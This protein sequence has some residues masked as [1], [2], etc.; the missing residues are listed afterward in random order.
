M[1]LLGLGAAALFGLVNYRAGR[2]IDSITARGVYTDP[3]TAG[4]PRA[5]PAARPDP[6]L[7]GG[8]IYVN[9]PLVK[10]EKAAGWSRPA[11]KTGQNQPEPAQIYEIPL[12]GV[13]FDI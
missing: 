2:E 12:D 7:K 9:P 1:I 5:K 13:V 8:L 6:E 11:A 3:V 4:E 10:P